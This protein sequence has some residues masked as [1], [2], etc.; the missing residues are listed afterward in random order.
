MH[1]GSVRRAKRR[2]VA[3]GSAALGTVAR[4]DRAQRPAHF[5]PNPSAEA[6]S[7]VVG[8]WV[9]RHLDTWC[10]GLIF[11]VAIVRPLPATQQRKPVAAPQLL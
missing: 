5:V 2:V 7:A 10:H 11:L 4:S 6:A 9:L 3:A 1:I 8:L